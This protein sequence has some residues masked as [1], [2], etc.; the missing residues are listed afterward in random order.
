MKIFVIGAGAMGSGIAQCFAA[1]NQV[2]LCDISMEYSQNGISKIKSGLDRMVS[3]GKME[4][5]QAANLVANL[6]PSASYQDAA[7]CDLVVEAA[8]ENMEIKKKVFQELDNICRPDTILA[9]NTSALSITEIAAATSRPDKVIGMHFFNPAPVIKLIE[10]VRGMDTSDETFNF[11]EKVSKDL[12]KAPVA[13][14]DYAGF[15]VNRILFPMLN[16]AV[17]TYADGVASIEDIDTGM[18]LGTNHPMGP[19]ELLDLVGIDIA[20]AILDTLYRELGNQK[21][22]PHPLLRKMVR[23]GKLGRKTGVGFYNYK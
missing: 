20:V 19:F 4:A 1:Q 5:E 17:S 22:C 21:Y 14:V 6:T 11:V 3:K 10:V 13:V 7:D 9:T 16:E 18:K 23:A 15:I 8:I 12:N 2:V